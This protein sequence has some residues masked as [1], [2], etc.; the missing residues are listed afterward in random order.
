MIQPMDLF[1]LL[2][3]TRLSRLVILVLQVGQCAEGCTVKVKLFVQD[4]S[5]FRRWSR[6]LA[7]IEDE[8]NGWLAANPGI[9]IVH[10][11]QSSNGGSFDTSKVF[12]SVWYEESA[13]PVNPPDR[14]HDDRII[15]R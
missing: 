15:E 3:R 6:F 5:P 7:Q 9:K 13:E 14:P 4:K 10:I 8:V 11:T 12:L 1:E 2:L